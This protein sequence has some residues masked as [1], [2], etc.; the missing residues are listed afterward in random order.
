VNEDARRHGIKKPDV[1]AYEVGFLGWGVDG[2]VHDML[3]LV[4]PSAIGED[5]SLHSGRL[6]HLTD[7]DYVVAREMPSYPILSPVYRSRKFEE[8]FRPVHSLP[9]PAAPYTVFAKR[10]AR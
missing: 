9:D 6:F 1:L 3:G 7:P 4:S 2:R 8:E 10:S 5:G